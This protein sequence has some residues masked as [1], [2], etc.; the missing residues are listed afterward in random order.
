MSRIIPLCVIFCLPAIAFAEGP[1]QPSDPKLL[2]VRKIW[3]QAPHNAF[4]GLV[5]FHDRWYC[6]FREGT[7]HMT[8]DGA[9]RV[10]SSADT[11]NWESA[12]HFTRPEKPLT[13]LRDAKICTTPDGRLML[14][15]TASRR[16]PKPGADPGP[17]ITGPAGKPEPLTHQSLVSFSK[18]GQHWTPPA[19]VGDEN[20][21]LW[22]VTW[23]KDIGYGIAYHTDAPYG[24][25]L[26]STKDG[27]HYDRINANLFDK[28]YPGE[29][30]LAFLPDDT[31]VC[32]LRREKGAANPKGSSSAVLGTARPPY[33]QWT[34]KDLGPHIGG[35]DMLLLNDGRLLAASRLDKP[36]VHTG[37]AWL[38]PD[39]ATLTECLPLPSGGDCSYPGMVLLD[40]TLY[41]SYYSSHEGKTSIYL[42]KIALGQ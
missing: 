1:A 34:W 32:L 26:Y 20:F 4:T 15:I 31:C 12:A 9:I 19:P 29:H 21:W 18:D 35:P 11:K 8:E 22:R 14:L 39:R 42:A 13:D 5:R 7:T 3:D 27:L 2:E 28:D 23:H 17:T 30:A 36:K 6:A 25:R 40:K 16:T 24:L 33:T 38:D 10:I 41:L 37:L